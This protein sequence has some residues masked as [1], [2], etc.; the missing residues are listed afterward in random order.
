MYLLATASP[1]IITNFRAALR[2]R[3]GT[4]VVGSLPDLWNTECPHQARLVL[5]DFGLLGSDPKPKIARTRQLMPSAKVLVITT[6]L[7]PESELSLLG[8]GVAGC[9]GVHLAEDTVARIIDTVLDGGTWISHAVLPLVLKGLRG[10]GAT[11]AP[12]ADPGTAS[13]ADRL[14]ALT[15]RER[16]IAELVGGGASNKQIARQLSITDRTVKA[17]LGAIF[18]KLSVSDRLQLALYVTGAPANGRA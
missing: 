5:I 1:Q 16:Q 2:K 15:P 13:G 9:C 3:G 12:A 10:L 18:Q 17:H 6:E 8:A 11:I 4:T 7:S 14:G